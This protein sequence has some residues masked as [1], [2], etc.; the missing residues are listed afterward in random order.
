MY[1]HSSVR[2]RW[3]LPLLILALCSTLIG[4]TVQAPVQSPFQEVIA[5]PN[6]FQPEGIAAGTGTTFYVGSIP[7][8][9]IYRGDVLTGTGEILVPAQ[10][11][12]VPPA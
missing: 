7:T 8:G 10:E 11:G 12:R 4:A 9:A 3:L 6:G 1:M 2:R 5:L